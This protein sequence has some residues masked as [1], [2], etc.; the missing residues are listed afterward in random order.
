VIRVDALSGARQLRASERQ[1]PAVSG[2]FQRQKKA[3]RRVAVE[4]PK[5]A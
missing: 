3:A 2:G 5:S 4:R 1:F